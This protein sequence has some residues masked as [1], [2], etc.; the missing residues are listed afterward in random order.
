MLQ[1]KQEKREE[2]EME[3]LAFQRN[4]RRK[5]NGFGLLL[6]SA[7]RLYE[8]FPASCAKQFHELSEIVHLEE[9]LMI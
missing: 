9:N 6:L 4:S 1:R 7:N 2:L 8:T 3:T 5:P